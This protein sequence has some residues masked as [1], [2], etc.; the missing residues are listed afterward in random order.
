MHFVK[1]ILKKPPRYTRLSHARAKTPKMSSTLNSRP[2]G[3]SQ[4]HPKKQKQSA[5]RAPTNDKVVSD[6][7][8]SCSSSSSQASICGKTT[9]EL[10]FQ[11]S[12]K[13]KNEHFVK[14]IL[15]KR[16]I[17]GRARDIAIG[18]EKTSART[19]MNT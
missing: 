1:D 8:I 15:E 14:D 19:P 17:A 16:E 4:R 18:A 3:S 12:A 9:T 10:L 6:V 5:P 13:G 7:H 11:P 2:S